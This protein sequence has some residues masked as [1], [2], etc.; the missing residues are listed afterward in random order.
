MPNL[1]SQ[2][3]KAWA[4]SLALLVI[5]AGPAGALAQEPITAGPSSAAVVTTVRVQT[6]AYQL[7][8]RGLRVPGYGTNSIPGAPALPV[9]S[10]IVELPLAGE[11]VV[12]AEAGAAQVLSHRPALP[13]VPVPQPADP[14]P[15]GWSAGVDQAAAVR[16]VDRPDP[17]IYGAD[18]FYPAS[19]VE[20]GAVQRQGGRRLLPLR[21]FPFQ[22]NPVAGALRYYPDLRV[23][24]SVRRDASAPTAGLS[25]TEA[26]AGLGHALNP[27]ALPQASGGALRIRTGAR[28]LHRLTWQ[29][30]VTAGVPVTTTSPVSFTVSYLGQP[31]DIQVVDKD[32]NGQFDPGDLVVF[33]AEPYAGRYQTDNVYWFTYG[34]TGSL[35]MGTRAVTLAPD[36]PVV[37]EITQTLHIENN[38]DYRSLYDRPKEADHWFDDILY[39]TGGSPTITRTYDLALD[40]ALTAGDRQVILAAVV[41]GGTDQAANPDQSM[42]IRLNSHDVGLYQWEGSTDI[43]ATATVSATWLDA[44]PNEVSLV[45]ALSQLPSLSYYWISP[46]YVELTYPALADAD[47]TDRLYIEAVAPGANRVEVTGFMTSTVGVYDIRDPRHPVQLM[48][49]EAQLAGGVYTLSF[50]DADLPGPTYT[51]S[52]EAVLL[53]PAAIEPD[54]SSAW[55]T[56]DHTADYIAIVHRDLWDAIDPLLAHRADPLG[57]NFSVAKVDV[58]DIY[59]EFS[60]GRRDPEAIRDFLSY[61]YHN[62]NGAGPRPQYVLLVGSGTYDFTGAFTGATKPNL[63]PPYLVDVDPWIGETAADNRYVSVDGPDDFLPDMHIGRI[64]AQSPAQVTAA[65]GKILAYEG[66][67]AAGDWQHRVVYVADD[68]ANYAEDFQALS[69]S[70]RLNWLPAPYED[71]TVYYGDP[72]VCPESSYANNW[73]MIWGISQEFN[74]GAFMVQ[75]FGHGSRFRW[76]DAGPMFRNKDVP[77][78]DANTAWP[79]TFAY[80]CWT[81]YF[82]NMHKL[83]SYDYMDETLGESLIL[84][85]QRGSVADLSPS[86][87]HVGGAL[88]TLNQGITQAIFQDAVDRM[89]QAVDAGKL[90]YWSQTPPYPD[91]IDTSIL[92]GDPATRLRLPPLISAARDIGNVT[93]ISWKHVSQYTTYQVWRS[94]RPYFSPYDVDAEQIGAVSGP[95]SEDVVFHDNPGAIGNVETNYFY[96]VRGINAAGMAGI[97]NRV[98]EFDFAL[99]P[100]N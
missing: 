90:Y 34:G 80:T 64:P 67:A 32:A 60:Y 9:W 92:F 65:V 31:V 58:Q 13:A 29:D 53:A 15:L 46:D 76:G 18:A 62:W 83:A 69:D 84:T 49:T 30:L 100:G 42:Q 54:T 44:S 47:G 71:R 16:T 37:T 8:A 26:G 59:D 2:I 68:C 97:S 57:D 12:T 85:S 6:P 4:A 51:L 98:G 43:T 66:T 5:L 72:A 38:V 48:T 1:R 70:V 87:Q 73:D 96:I 28:G 52:T 21:V 78:L 79:I 35:P 86:G 17:A 36:A 24:V 93:K 19:L 45:A 3:R 81:G 99:V 10:T 94:T 55:G 82:V 95:F 88:V 14:N 89:G 20:A 22:Y 91:V 23:T 77:V 41:H 25:M 56:R 11:P 33:Y 63:I 27:A 74:N 50:W 61:A 75:W 40:D 7:D 39:P